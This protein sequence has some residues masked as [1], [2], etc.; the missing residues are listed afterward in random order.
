M[1]D[2]NVVFTQTALQV[3]EFKTY[4]LHTFVKNR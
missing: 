4:N 2:A 3:A 1:K